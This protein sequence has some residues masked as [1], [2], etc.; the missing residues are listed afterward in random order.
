MKSQG[1]FA[2][3]GGVMVLS[4]G[5]LLTAGCGSGGG[6]GAECRGDRPERRHAE[7]G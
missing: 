7:L 4:V 1:F 6:L 2:V 3:T 5:L